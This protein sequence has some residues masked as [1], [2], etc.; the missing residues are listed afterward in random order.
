M[1]GNKSDWEQR[2]VVPKERG[3]QLATLQS[4]PFLETSA[5]TNTNINEAFETLA[6]VILEKVKKKR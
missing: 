3:Q 1:I 2:R 4:I 5:K 6:H